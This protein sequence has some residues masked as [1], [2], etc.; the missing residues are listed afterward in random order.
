MEKSQTAI[1]CRLPADFHLDITAEVCPLTFVRTRLLLERMAPGQVLEIRLK[2]AEPLENIP[3]ALVEE[4]HELLALEP[5]VN[6]PEVIEPGA[7]KPGATGPGGA[8]PD[9][10]VPY[11]LVVRK[12]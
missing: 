7:L 8:S 4:G 10:A 9:S 11:R 3:R 5:E 1:I 6:E 12:G 2:G